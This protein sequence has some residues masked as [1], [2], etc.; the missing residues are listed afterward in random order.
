LK[1][2]PRI[3]APANE[4][5]GYL[6]NDLFIYLYLEFLAHGLEYSLRSSVALL[7]DLRG[8]VLLHSLPPFSL[9]INTAT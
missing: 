5:A 2:L 3:A 1:E 6:G 7:H 4:G 9:Y 8:P